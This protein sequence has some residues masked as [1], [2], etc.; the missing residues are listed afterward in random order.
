[1]PGT[2]CDG[3]AGSGRLPAF[4]FMG[5]PQRAIQ[6]FNVFPSPPYTGSFYGSPPRFFHGF[7]PFSIAPVTTVDDIPLVVFADYLVPAGVQVLH[8][9]LLYSGIA[10]IWP[11]KLVSIMAS[12]VNVL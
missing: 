11:K 2:K 9:S 8:G 4:S 5:T 10:R 3:R 6:G 7:I 12:V 1:M